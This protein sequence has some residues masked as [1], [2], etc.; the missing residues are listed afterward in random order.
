MCEIHSRMLG[1]FIAGPGK[2]L[3]PCPSC[4][5]DDCGALK[6]MA[7]V[8]CEKCGHPIGFETAFFFAETFNDPDPARLVHAKCLEP[9]DDRRYR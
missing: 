2:P 5:H 9:A 3:G 8:K 1:R 4:W 6:R 7:A